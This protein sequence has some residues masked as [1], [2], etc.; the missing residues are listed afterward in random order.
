MNNSKKRLLS[1]EKFLSWD[2]MFLWK[3]KWTDLMNRPHRVLL[4]YNNKPA[5]T[6]RIRYTEKGMKLERIAV[7]PES[8]RKGIGTALMHFLVDYS[9]NS[10]VKPVMM[11][12]QYYLLGFYQRFGFKP[13]GPIFIDAGIRHIEMVLE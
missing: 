5:G 12:A 3:E 7:L 10:G 2:R 8:R 11:H 6:A 13:R 1:D 4:H 9:R